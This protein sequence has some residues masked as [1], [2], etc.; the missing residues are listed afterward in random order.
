M[1][2]A[3]GEQTVVVRFAMVW[4]K[5][6]QGLKLVQ[7]MNTVPTVGQS[8]KELLAPKNKQLSIELHS[9]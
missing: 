4:K 6:P 1:H 7:E 3:G 9:G 8:A 5:T 2:R